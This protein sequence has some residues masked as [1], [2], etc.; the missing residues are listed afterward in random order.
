[1][2]SSSNNVLK[3]RLLS[4]N[5]SSPLAS[6]NFMKNIG[7][8][9][10]VMEVF[11]DNNTDADGN[12]N[13]ETEDAP[14]IVRKPCMLPV[15][16]KRREKEIEEEELAGINVDG[17]RC[18]PCRVG[19]DGI[20]EGTSEML[21]EIYDIDRRMFLTVPDDEIFNIM[22]SQYNDTIYKV[23]CILGKKKG[24][25][26][27]T[28]AGVR[29]HMKKH[30]KSNPRRMIWRH[31]SHIDEALEHI[32]ENGYYENE[33]RRDPT[34]GSEVDLGDAPQINPKNNKIY[35]GLLK[36]LKELIKLDNDTKKLMMQDDANNSGGSSKSNSLWGANPKAHNP[37]E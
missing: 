31:I 18:E 22:A 20:T 28:K 30:A 1:M 35:T 6:T 34:D 26:K 12:G 16:Y 7:A 24:L 14:I 8:S 11:M 13:P 17:H 29:V 15:Q 27:W 23:D 5:P 33:F 25:K 32:V 4:G 37:Y 19:N 9:E 36:E 10:D 2:P 3:N 21:Q